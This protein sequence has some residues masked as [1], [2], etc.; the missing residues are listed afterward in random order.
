MKLKDYD[1][2]EW[3]L[4]SRKEY[5]SLIDK[6]AANGVDTELLKAVYAWLIDKNQLTKK[7]KK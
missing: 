6:A 2:E 1:S 4:V 5:Q 7:D 3:L